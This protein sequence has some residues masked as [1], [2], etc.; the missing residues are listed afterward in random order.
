MDEESFLKVIRE[1]QAA[2]GR[3]GVFADW[4]EEQGRHDE[5]HRERV[6]AEM[7]EKA[8]TYRHRKAVGFERGAKLVSVI[9]TPYTPFNSEY[10]SCLIDE[11]GAIP[12]TTGGG[13][14][15]LLF[16][17][18]AVSVWSWIRNGDWVKVETH[19]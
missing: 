9:R 14:V 1:D 12:L 10:P 15:A 4:L 2:W 13:V 7:L 18:D 3:R 16:C 17:V 5:A 8:E 19:Q 6:A 11:R